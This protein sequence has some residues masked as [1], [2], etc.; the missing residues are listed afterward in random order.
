M[1]RVIRN[2]SLF[3]L[4]IGL[5][6]LSAR[7]QDTGAA[8]QMK[9][10]VQASAGMGFGREELENRRQEIVVANMKFT[11]DD[12]K[13]KFLALYIPYQ[14][15]LMN[16][17]KAR[18]RLLDQYQQDQQNGVISDSEATKILNEN[19]RLDRNRVEAEATYLHSL[20][21]VMPMEQALRAYEI[22][23]RLNAFYL[24]DILGS[25]HLVK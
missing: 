21:A 20:K 6:P 4:V 1:N 16:N 14:E 23:E 5:I 10:E 15:K 2:A 12:Q 22:D 3:L 18:K 13:N 8:N 7:A 9:S 17:L 24:N 25:I 11:N 19:L